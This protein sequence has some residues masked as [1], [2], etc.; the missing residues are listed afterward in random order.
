MSRKTELTKCL[1]KKCL[2]ITSSNYDISAEIQFS[3]SSVAHSLDTLT[4]NYPCTYIIYNIFY[5]Y[6]YA[7][8]IIVFTRDVTLA[9]DMCHRRTITTLMFLSYEK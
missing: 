7:V 1:A 3:P 6:L 8:E 2:I 4:R 5:V 9:L